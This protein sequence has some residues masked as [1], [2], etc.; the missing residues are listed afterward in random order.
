MLYRNKDASV[1]CT[2]LTVR[3]HKEK[4]GTEQA[5]QNWAKGSSV[6]HGT[7]QKL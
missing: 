5:E 7:M 2:A 3:G 6:P 1:S 4:G